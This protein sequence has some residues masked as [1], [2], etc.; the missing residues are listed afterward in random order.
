MTSSPELHLFTKTFE[1]TKVFLASQDHTAQ[2]WGFWIQL[3]AGGHALLVEFGVDV[4]S[5]LSVNDSQAR[6]AP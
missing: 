4:R 5:G 2:A 6:R 3:G 1:D